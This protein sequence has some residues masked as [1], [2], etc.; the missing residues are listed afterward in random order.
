MQPARRVRLTLK[1]TFVKEGQEPR[2]KASGH[3][4]A[5]QFLR[6]RRT[7]KRQRTILGI[8]LRE[9]R[10][11]HRGQC[12]SLTRQQRRRLRRRPAVEPTIGHLKSD[13]RSDHCWLRGQLG[14]AL[15]TVLCATDYNLRWLLRAMGRLGLKAA[16]LRSLWLTL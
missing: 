8:V 16:F 4:H 14:D 2:R 15:H 13:Y 7:V 6:L 5:R 11:N 9:V 3:A 12:K 1:Q 10:R